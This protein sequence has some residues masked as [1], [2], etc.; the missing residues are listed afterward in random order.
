MSFYPQFFWPV[1][2]GSYTAG[3]RGRGG[4]QFSGAKNY[5][6]SGIV[7]RN[8]HT[9]SMNSAGVRYY[10]GTTNLA[11]RISNSEVKSGLGL[12]FASN[13]RQLPGRFLRLG[14]F[15]VFLD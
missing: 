1:A 8:C 4:W 11:D 3:D 9:A 5:C 7:F 2:P 12:S 13:A 10:N 15:A 6:V 14:P